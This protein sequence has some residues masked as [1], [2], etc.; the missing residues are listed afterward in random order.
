[1][2]YSFF[3]RVGGVGIRRIRLYVRC[4][5]HGHGG[6]YYVYGIYYKHSIEVH[7]QMHIY[8]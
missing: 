3:V 4:I 6:E 8:I 5:Y 7:I 2:E 1:M